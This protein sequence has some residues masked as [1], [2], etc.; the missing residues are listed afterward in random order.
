[1]TRKNAR[2]ANRNPAG[3]RVA[4]LSQYISQ[5]IYRKTIRYTTS[6]GNTQLGVGI[7]PLLFGLG[8]MCTTAGTG[9]TLTSLCQCFRLRRV[10]IWSVPPSAG[11][12]ATV[13]INWFPSGSADL[14][15]AYELSNTSMSISVPAHVSSTPP[16]NT[17]ASFWQNP[18]T[19][20]S[21]LLFVLTA[22]ADSIV[23]VDLDFIL[24]DNEQSVVQY[25][26]AST[27]TLGKVY[28]VCLDGGSGTIVPVNLTAA[29]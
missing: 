26:T 16:R 8:G 29:N 5:P 4:E 12:T 28:Y 21:G 2:R 7:K 3:T 24:S 13:E 15:P 11:A 9:G 18:T 1:M 17:L 10:Q 6:A 25:S 27:V 20:S 22:P 14:V 19:A 23:E